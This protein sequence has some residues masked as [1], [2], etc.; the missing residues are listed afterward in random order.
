MKLVRC[1][2]VDPEDVIATYPP[3]LSFEIFFLNKFK[4][5]P[6]DAT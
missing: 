5:F 1:K 6:D 4:Y 2:A 3:P